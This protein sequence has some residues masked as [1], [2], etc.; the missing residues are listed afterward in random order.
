MCY[1]SMLIVVFFILFIVCVVALGG[2]GVTQY[3]VSN[4]VNEDIPEVRVNVCILFGTFN[5]S[6]TLE[7]GTEVVFINMTNIGSCAFALWGLISIMLVAFMWLIS[8]FIQVFIGK[9]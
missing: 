2:F 6:R 7:D 8:A 3:R 1:F 9:V 5:S 4:F